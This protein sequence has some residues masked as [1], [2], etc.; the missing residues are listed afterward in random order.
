MSPDVQAAVRRPSQFRA[1]I[2]G[3]RAV[4]VLAVVA[5]HAGLPIPGGFLGV[6]VFFVISGFVITSSLAREWAE[7]GRLSLSGFYF[8]RLKRLTPALAAMVVIV[9]VISI[10]VLSPLGGQQEAA[11]TGA[12]ALL[13][14]ANFVLQRT[15]G[16][17]F[18]LDADLNPLLHTW[19]LSVEEQIY[20]VVPLVLG[21]SWLLAR[22]TGGRWVPVAAIAV[23]TALSLACV[24]F[25]PLASR[26]PETLG[27]FF[28]PVPRVW[29]FGVGVLL[30][31]LPVARLPRGAAP[32]LGVAGFACVAAGFML[33]SEQSAIP[34]RGMALPVLG[35][36]AIIAAGAVT[37]DHL[38]AR[39]LRVRPMA[40]LGDLSYSWYLWHWPFVVFGGL[41]SGGAPVIVLMA[42][43]LSLV[44]AVLSYRYLEQPVRARVLD[45]RRGRATLVAAVLV[46]PLVVATA[47]GGFAAAGYG[48]P[49]VRAL[50]EGTMPLHE[51]YRAGCTWEIYEV[52]DTRC[53]WNGD[54]TSKP[55]YL[56]GDSNADHFAEAL[57]EVAQELD[58]PLETALASGCPPLTISIT[59]DI[60]GEAGRERC[61]VFAASTLGWLD[62]APSGTV[63]L[64]ITSTYWSSDVFAVGVPGAQTTDSDEKLAEFRTA[65]DD[66]LTRLTAAGHDVVVVQPIPRFGWDPQACSLATIVAE[67]CVGSIS[68]AALEPAQRETWVVVREVADSVGVRVLDLT[69][70]LCASDCRTVREDGLV[71]YRDP[72]HISVSGAI[73]LSG[74]FRDAIA[75]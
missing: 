34:G 64:A 24:F 33:V 11:M 1:D 67:A 32:V 50:Q 42:A 61:E 68:Q 38:V 52:D 37:S 49:V 48:L 39:A 23:I 65:L 28:G 70:L 18:D 36:A 66:G 31:L 25:P 22:L 60:L 14:G 55:L 73:V 62:T 54:S 40:A 5:Y 63:V 17:Y 46:P 72:D 26:L 13:L 19:S 8:R 21:A 57:I 43:V 12:G 59:R 9:L 6:D 35:A 45:R 56:I 51:T 47:V 10:A 4:A 69:P 2:Q 20:L 71:M 7:T 74:A 30:A 27:G 16:G 3:L 44:P 58:R 53:E 15:V 41:L 29:E 75:G